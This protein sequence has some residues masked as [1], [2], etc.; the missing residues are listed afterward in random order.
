[1]IKVNA[2][3]D[4]DNN[5]HKTEEECKS[6]DDRIK[7]RRVI[8][9]EVKIAMQ[10]LS[11]GNVKRGD[12]NNENWIQHDPNN[13]LDAARKLVEITKKYCGPTKIFDKITESSTISEITN[14][15]TFFFGRCHEANKQQKSIESAV[16]RLDCIRSDGREFGQ[17]FFRVC[18][19]SQ[20][21][22]VCLLDNTSGEK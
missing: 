12:L 2:W 14:I 8:E 20:V 9:D 19:D 13:V 17:P 6:E 21:V 11:T 3:M 1:M 18:H 10:N 16:Y 22:G 15:I 7:S 4:D 5:L